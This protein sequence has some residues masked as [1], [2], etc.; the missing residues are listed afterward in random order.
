MLSYLELLSELH[1]VLQPRSYLEVGVRHGKSLELASCPAVGVD[2]VPELKVELGPAARVYPMTSDDFFAAGDGLD[3]LPGRTI[4]LAFIDG[5]HLVEY[6]YRDV[7]NVERHCGPGSVI[8][9]D[10]MLPRTELEAA[11]NRQTRAWTGDV[12]K[13]TAVLE[14]RRP[15]LV[16]IPVA[17]RPTGFLVVLCPDPEAPAEAGVSRSDMRRLRKDAA[18]PESVLGRSAAVDP[19]Q[20]VAAPFWESVRAARTGAVDADTVRREVVA[21]RPRPLSLEQVAESKGS[22]RRRR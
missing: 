12:W 8:V 21:W 16:L 20:L 5:M 14:Q 3:H 19:A 18:P 2:P 15:D 11:R 9:M 10:D 13:V 22:A 17:V 1:R 4:D 6:A 7:V